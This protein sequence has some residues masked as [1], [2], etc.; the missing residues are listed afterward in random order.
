MEQDK[1]KEDQKSSNS[2]ENKI[3]IFNEEC[4]NEGNLLNS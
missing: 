3:K 2:D 4:D 1:L